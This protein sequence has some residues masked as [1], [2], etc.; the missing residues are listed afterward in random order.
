MG[1]SSMALAFATGFGVGYIRFAPGTFGSLLGLALWA[2]VPEGAVAH[3]LAI[4]VVFVAGAWSAA[5]AERRLNAT[6][7]GPVVIDEVLGMLVTLF[8][9]PVGWSGA[10]LG[11]LFFRVFDVAKPYPANRLER[12]H[13][14]V[15]VMADDA[16]AAIYANVALRIA[17]AVAGGASSGAGP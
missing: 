2:V 11:F 4:A 5:I 15:G 16:M 6:D 13:G 10:L 12:L 1:L 9:V 17:L 14:G 7:P 8:M 3:A